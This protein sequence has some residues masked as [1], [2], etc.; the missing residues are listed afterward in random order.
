M[1]LWVFKASWLAA[2]AT[3]QCAASSQAGA[4][5]VA[6]GLGHHSVG[7]PQAQRPCPSRWRY[8]FLLWGREGT[9][10]DYLPYARIILENVWQLLTAP[11]G[12]SWS[13]FH[14]LEKLKFGVVSIPGLDHTAANGRGRTWTGFWLTPQ[15]LASRAVENHSLETEVWVEQVWVARC[16]KNGVEISNNNLP[17]ENRSVRHKD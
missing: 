7:W 13:L 3:A 15:A 9:S 4:S 2:H 5:M 17:F 1:I 16:L 12:R 11:G 10:I 6:R 8:T 14:E